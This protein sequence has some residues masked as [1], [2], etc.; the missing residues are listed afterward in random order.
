[1]FFKNAFLLQG[2][3]DDSFSEFPYIF[4]MW[5]NMTILVKGYGV[6]SFP[7]GFDIRLVLLWDWL[8]IK[9]RTSSFLYY[10]APSSCI[11]NWN[12]M[13][14]FE[15]DSLNPSSASR[16][17]MSPSYPP[18]QYI[19]FVNFKGIIMFGCFSNRWK[20][21]RDRVLRGFSYSEMKTNYSSKP[22]KI[23][24]MGPS[25]ALSSSIATKRYCRGNG[26]LVAR[27][28]NWSFAWLLLA[29][30]DEISVRAF[31]SQVLSIGQ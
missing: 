21:L 13:S 1:M 27:R 23:V 4:N 20:D 28:V 3:G 31:I 19:F 29:R 22:G 15:F 12:S 11:P 17:V 2:V 7:T 5:I 16:T 14:V 24:N 18:M 6:V 8:S 9:A 30:I 10:F 25:L 26:S